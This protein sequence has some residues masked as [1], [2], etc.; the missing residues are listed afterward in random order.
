MSASSIHL[1]MGITPKV[2]NDTITNASLPYAIQKNNHGYQLTYHQRSINIILA[3]QDPRI[4]AGLTLPVTHVTLD[5]INHSADEI[6]AYMLRFK[7]Y[8]HR[9]GG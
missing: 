9:G 5:F 7:R 3:V 4:I 8:F 2:F 1:E 6:E